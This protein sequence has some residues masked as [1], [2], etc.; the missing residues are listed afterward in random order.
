[1]S[2]FGNYIK[3]L[4]GN[5]SLRE[6]ERLSNV[7]HTYISKLEKGFDPRSGEKIVPSIDTIKKLASA[8]DIDYVELMDKAGY[9]DD[10][11]NVY[12]KSELYNELTS[13]LKVMES[14]I[15][16]M[17]DD[18][19]ESLKQGTIPLDKWLLTGNTTWRGRTLTVGNARD[20]MAFLDN[21]L[22]NEIEHIIKHLRIR[23]NGRKLNEKDRERILDMIK[24]LFPEDASKET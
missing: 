13:G 16:N 22:D 6:L 18:A 2:E 17:K 10:D 24:V 15:Q 12:L 23:Y 8:F 4:R 3:E 14:Q 5:K 20:L 21:C 11:A 9:F 1:M 19:I 7:S